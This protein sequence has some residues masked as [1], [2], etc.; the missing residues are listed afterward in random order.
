LIA[1]D[2]KLTSD[3]LMDLYRDNIHVEK[4]KLVEQ[5]EPRELLATN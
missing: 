1:G 5:F 4:A 2:A 3:S